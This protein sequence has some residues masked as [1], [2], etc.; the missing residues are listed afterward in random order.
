MQ[1]GQGDGGQDRLM[2]PRLSLEQLVDELL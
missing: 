1:G 2:L